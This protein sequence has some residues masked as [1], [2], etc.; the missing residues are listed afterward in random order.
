MLLKD[1]SGRNVTLLMAPIEHL[2]YTF[3]VEHCKVRYQKKQHSFGP[4]KLLKIFI[5]F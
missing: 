2:N 4:V 5:D 1:L 3:S